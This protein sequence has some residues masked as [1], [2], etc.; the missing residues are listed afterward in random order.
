MVG[1]LPLSVYLL[2]ATVEHFAFR[3][4]AASGDQDLFRRFRTSRAALAATFPQYFAPRTTPR[5]SL[6][7]GLRIFAWIVLIS[8][9]VKRYGALDS[10]IPRLPPAPSSEG[11]NY[12]KLESFQL[13]RAQINEIWA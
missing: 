1:I 8:A 2:S 4:F 3:V 10:N 13:W 11:V 9:P 7:S 12:P 5:T 6:Y